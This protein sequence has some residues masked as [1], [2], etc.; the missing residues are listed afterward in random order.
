MSGLDDPINDAD[1]LNPSAMLG[2][3]AELNLA[4]AA[5]ERAIRL[6]AGAM[7]AAR[8]LLIIAKPIAAASGVPLGTLAL[9]V[10]SAALNMAAKE[11]S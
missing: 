10:A 9:D 7:D 5:I 2:T 3:T 1:R 11:R 8:L 4:T 6:Q